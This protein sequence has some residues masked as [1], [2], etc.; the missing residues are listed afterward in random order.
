MQDSLIINISERNR[1]IS[2][3]FLHGN[4]HQRK[5][6]HKT[7]PVLVRC[8]QFCLPSNQIAGFF[9]HQYLLEKSSGLSFFAWR[10]SS[11]QGSTWDDL[12]LV[13][14]SYFS[15]TIRVADSL[16]NCKTRKNQLMCLSFCMKIIIKVRKHLRLSRLVGYGQVFL[17]A[18]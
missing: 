15:H 7:K 3:D 18:Y 8:G 10:W 2:L 4:Y 16:I 1:S 17:R 12:L 11:R 9:D 6:A 5:V 13:V 14:P